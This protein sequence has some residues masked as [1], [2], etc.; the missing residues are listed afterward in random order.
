[1][2]DLDTFIIIVYVFVDDWY[3]EH[4]APVKPKLGRPATFSDSE[5][6]TL[7]IVSEWRTGMSWRS[8]R[9]FLRFMHK[10]YGEWFPHLPQRSAFNERKRRFYGIITQLHQTLVEM[11]STKQDIYESV[12]LLPIPAGTLGQYSRDLG[13]WLWESTIGYGQG[14]LFWGDRLL[15]AVRPSGVI[16][17]WLLAAADIND[18][19]IMEAFVSARQGKPQ[20]VGPPHRKRDGKKAKVLPP[21]GLIGGW[22]NVGSM[23]TRPYIADKGFNG[24]RWRMHWQQCYQAQVISVPPNNSA[25]ERPWTWQEK[26][27]LASHRQI[28]ETVF[29]VLDKVFDIKR[30]AAHSRWGQ[31]TRIAAKMV[32]Y[33]LG[34]WINRTLG[35]GNLQHETLVC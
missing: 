25:A 12:D 9:G 13:H 34:I 17:G 7:A 1:M 11:L 35:R 5:L 15:G 8:E 19:W 31:Y 3:Q 6:L 33:H 24:H 23:H 18:R 29:A 16:S 26:L 28:V 14:R 2:L 21:V 10:H 20:L 27:W 32:G 4:I 30:L 22:A